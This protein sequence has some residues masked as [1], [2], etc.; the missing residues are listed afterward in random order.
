LYPANSD[1]EARR[2]ALDIARDATL[3]LQ[4]RTWARAQTSTGKSPAF[5]YLF[6]RV[7]PYTP[8][9][10]FSDHDPATIGAYHTADVPYWLQTLDSLNLFRTTR[11]WTPY[12]RELTTRMSD[13]IVSF[14][15]TGKPVL[16]GVDWPVYRSEDERIVELGD[17]VRVVALPNS[18]KLD[19]LAAH[20][21]RE[22]V[23][24]E[25]ARPRNRD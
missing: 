21:P 19:F 23:M 4:T 25:G 14:A 24:G 2:G 7:H 20:P 16:S 18:S 17:S 9:V 6:S 5:L 11:D 8:G 22:P 15:R 3:G 1:A 12:D 10:K 13:V